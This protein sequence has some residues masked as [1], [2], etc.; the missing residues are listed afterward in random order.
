M[1]P[2]DIYSVCFSATGNTREVVNIITQKLAEELKSIKFYMEFTLPKG[3]Q[4]VM[5]FPS[6]SLVVFGTPT[7][8]GRI[9]NKI[10]PFIR[11]LFKGGGALAIPVVTF[12]NRSFDNSLRELC[13]ELEA[14]GFRT[15]AAAA[16]V[17][18][19]PFSSKVGTGRP[20][21]KDRK[22]LESF[23]KDASEKIK[24]ARTKDDLPSPIQVE[25][26]DELEGYYIPL[27]ADGKAVNFLK[28]KPKT[29][30]DK[31][32]HCG[33]CAA[34]CPMEA[35]DFG[36]ESLVP[37]TCIK[38]HSCVKNCPSGAK[39]FDDENFL[40]HVRMLERDHGVENRKESRFYI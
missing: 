1:R 10:L 13:S 29:H 6:D 27:G 22:G 38:C 14:L 23:I 9:P 19:H 24:G 30:E 15:I 35:I 26:N 32:D 16:L 3:R 20:D 25:G 21:S 36:D 5:E 17:G 18:E 39:Y 31:C 28:A 37:G 8:A 33:I 34:L 12:G 4:K 11:T 40:S 2:I 7:Y